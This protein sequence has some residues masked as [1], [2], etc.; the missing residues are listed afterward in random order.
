MPLPSPPRKFSSFFSL[1]IKILLTVLAFWLAFRDVEWDAFTAMLE[2]QKHTGLALAAGCIFVQVVMGAL[3]WR[4]ILAALSEQGKKVISYADAFKL[5]YISVFFSNCLP[6]TIGG[7][8]VRVWI[9]RSDTIPLSLSLNSIIIDRLLALTGLALVLLCMLPVLAGI[10]QVDAWLVLING[11]TLAMIG[12][13]LIVKTDHALASFEHM[14]IIRWLRYFFNC[15]R[16]LIRNPIMS[17]QSL[18]A[19]AIAHVFFGMASYALAISMDVD[20]S[21]LTCM[22][23]M[24]LVMLVIT[25]PISIGGWG[26]REMVMVQLFA[27]VGVAGTEAVAISL[28]LGLL[29][30]L[31]SLPAALLWLTFKKRR[32]IEKL[33]G[34]LPELP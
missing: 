31:V 9:T 27:L 12:S 1:G 7:D 19:A 13:W 29:N 3:R 32:H 30:M 6:G 25:L 33:P 28:Q 8:L 11:L 16:L 15:L 22:A 18:I 17:A 34:T 2:K 20:V 4:Y 10:L 23:L 21:L 24:P 26:V 14:R 5:Y